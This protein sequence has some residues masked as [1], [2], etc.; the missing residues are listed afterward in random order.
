[1]G[2][3]QLMYK[4]WVKG[5]LFL[6]MQVGF[7][8]FFALYGGKA[9][10]GFFILGTVQTNPWYGIEGDN[11]ITMRIMGILAFIIL[12][13]Y[14]AIYWINLR[15]VRKTQLRVEGGSKPLTIREET[16]MLL[17]SNFHMT[18]PGA[19]HR[20]RMRFLHIA[21]YFHDPDCVYQLRW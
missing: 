13:L 1:M 6:L 16:R 11:S 10:A 8:A 9:L 12:F 19:A 2:L 14:F 7:V 4:Q 18:A 20:W 5:I 17:D 3:G 15:D 21:Y